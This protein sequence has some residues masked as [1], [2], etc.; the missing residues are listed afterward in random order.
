MR[1]RCWTCG[2]GGSGIALLGLRRGGPSDREMVRW[3][4]CGEVVWRAE[5]WSAEKRLRG[6]RRWRFEKTEGCAESIKAFVAGDR[7]RRVSL[8]GRGRRERRCAAGKAG[9]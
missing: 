7:R 9:V 8:E 5:S 4:H 1:E 3:V 6:K 2:N